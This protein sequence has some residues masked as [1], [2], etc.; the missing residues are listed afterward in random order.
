LRHDDDRKRESKNNRKS[1]EAIFKANRSGRQALP[2]G[3]PVTRAT[4][5]PQGCSSKKK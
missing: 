3:G 5:F 1:S 4:V 2:V